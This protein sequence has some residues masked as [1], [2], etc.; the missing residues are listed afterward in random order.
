MTNL[1]ISLA[2]YFIFIFLLCVYDGL[3]MHSTSSHSFFSAISLLTIRP[4]LYSSKLLYYCLVQYICPHA[5]DNCMCVCLSLSLYSKSSLT[6]S[7]HL[8]FC[9]PLLLPPLMQCCILVVFFF[10]SF[11]RVQT[12]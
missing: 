4:L 9:V 12:V 10:P 1:V 11:P 7:I 8:F 2:L 5:V 6:L 3:I